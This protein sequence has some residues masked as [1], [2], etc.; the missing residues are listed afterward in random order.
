MFPYETRASLCVLAT[1]SLKR[2][3]SG[4]SDNSVQTVIII[5]ST[6]VLLQNH[7][8]NVFLR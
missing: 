1:C 4:N 3:I 2:F 8:L 7:A 5:G 6:C